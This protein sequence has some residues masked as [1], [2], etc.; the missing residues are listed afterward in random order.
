MY[1]NDFVFVFGMPGDAAT[2][3][4]HKKYYIYWY[5]FARLIVRPVGISPAVFLNKLRSARMYNKNRS[6]LQLIANYRFVDDAHRNS[7]EKKK[8]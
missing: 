4:S 7:N 3:R 1:T 8:R 6:P 5:A 2:Q